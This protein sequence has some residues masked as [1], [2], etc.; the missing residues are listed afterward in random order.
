[1]PKE[2]VKFSIHYRKQTPKLKYLRRMN[3]K[4]ITN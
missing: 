2:I 4:N 1:M 3:V